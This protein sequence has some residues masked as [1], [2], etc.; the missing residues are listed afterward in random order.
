MKTRTVYF[1]IKRAIPECRVSQEAC[2]ELAFY[3][4]QECQRIAKKAHQF[5][6]H[7]G[8]E[9]IVIADVKLAIQQKE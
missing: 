6:R 2:K 3:L 1:E 9:T 5:A 7:A 4:R 8:R